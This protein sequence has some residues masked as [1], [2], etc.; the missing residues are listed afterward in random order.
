[1]RPC[2]NIFRLLMG[3]GSNMRQTGF[4]TDGWRGIIADG[5]T[6]EN[7]GVMTQAV[8][9]FLKSGGGPK[10]IYIG[11]DTRFMSREY[12]LL[13]A[14]VVAGNGYKAVVGEQCVTTP[15]LSHAVSGG[16]ASGGL[17]ITASHNPCIYNGIKFKPQYG[18]SAYP[19]LTSEV[20]KYIGCEPVI[21]IPYGA[22]RHRG[23]AVEAD[24][25]GPYRK[26]LYGMLD[27]E[28]ITHGAPDAVFDC[29]HGAAGPYAGRLWEGLGLTLKTLRAERD[30]YFG[31]CA[32]EPVE[33]NLSALKDEVAGGGYAVGFATDGDGDRLGVV[34]SSGRFMGAHVVMSLLMMHLTKDRGMRGAVVKT[35]STSSLVD[36][37]AAGLGLPVIETPVGFK[38]IC[39]VMLDRDVL[40]GGEENG[41]LGIKGFIPERD[42]LLAALLVLEMMVK[43]R[44]GI[45]KL[46][47]KLDEK[48]G[49]LYYRRYDLVLGRGIDADGF[50]R[51]GGGLVHLFSDFGRMRISLLDGYKAVFADGSWILFRLS[52]TEPLIR[53]YAESHEPGNVERLIDRAKEALLG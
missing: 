44:A 21:S 10:K 28:A 48:Y 47:E 8:M 50:K 26:D 23:K 40:I 6:M 30:P 37:V 29:M 15:M 43:E 13:A 27:T 45:E 18:G 38:H 9:S 7:L 14:S 51:F 16:R 19:A 20:E 33:A 25:F 36:R 2:V 52:G 11:Y 22:A 49:R 24:F 4:G 42:G 46:V 39:E 41:G 32:P 5:F 1:M 17:M 35:V 31:G 34:D 12:A 53:V 3:E